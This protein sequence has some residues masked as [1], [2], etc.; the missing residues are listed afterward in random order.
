MPSV[1]PDKV[2]LLFKFPLLI[3]ELLFNETSPAL[4]KSLMIVIEFSSPSATIFA[5]LATSSPEAD[6][7]KRPLASSDPV[8]ALLPVIEPVVLINRLLSLDI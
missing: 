1:L 6:K 7:V 3:L 5:L 8:R 2:A 4:L